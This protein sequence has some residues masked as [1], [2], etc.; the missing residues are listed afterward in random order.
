MGAYVWTE[1]RRRAQAERARAQKPWLKSTGPRSVEGKKIA[2]RNSYKHGL[3][4]APVHNLRKYMRDQRRF[5]AAFLYLAKNRRRFL[6]FFRHLPLSPVFEKPCILRL[7]PSFSIIIPT[8]NREDLLPKTVRSIL[9]Q[10]LVDWELIIIDDGSSDNTEAAMAQFRQDF[11]IAYSKQ[12]NAGPAAARN[13]GLAKAKGDVIVYIDSDD[14]VSPDFLSTIKKKLRDHPEISFGVCNHYR[15]TEF[16][17]SAQ[18]VLSAIDETAPEGE[19]ITLQDLYDWKVK[20]TS[21]GLFHRREKFEGKV[22]WRDTI[23]IEDLE[24]I[25]QLAVLD[26]EG[27]LHIPDYLV[28]YTQ[29]YGEENGGMCSN[30]SYE[31]YAKAFGMIYELHKN[32]FH[33]KNPEVYLTRVEK[34]NELQQKF[35]AGEERPNLYKYFPELWENRRQ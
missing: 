24:L 13:A 11:R 15:R 12:E 14:T 3:R 20:T 35:L 31:D 22:E 17:D 19:T 26:P 2:S 33:M 18:K 1:E 5:V 4:S 21:T 8:Y 27:F 32:D 6:K 25:M 30:A 34:Y 7:M 10:S 29:R 9:A 28:Q 23:M 16:V